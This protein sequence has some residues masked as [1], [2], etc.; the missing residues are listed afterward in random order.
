[1][2]DR[3]FSALPVMDVVFSEFSLDITKG[4]EVTWYKVW[5]VSRVRYPLVMFRVKTFNESLCIM[6]T[7]IVQMDLE[8]FT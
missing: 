3:A 4:E 5:A 1:V 6:R 2:G 7:C 8:T